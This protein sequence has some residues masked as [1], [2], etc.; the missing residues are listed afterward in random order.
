MRFFAKR[1][2]WV[3][4]EWKVPDKEKGEG[5]FPESPPIS[6]T[7]FPVLMMEQGQTKKDLFTKKKE[8]NKD[9]KI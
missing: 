3:F 9:V 4:P 8:V 5:D 1:F 2:G 7:L 6:T